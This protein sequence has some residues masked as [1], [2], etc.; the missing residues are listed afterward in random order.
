MNLEKFALS[1]FRQRTR[2]SWSIRL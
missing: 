1:D 2:S